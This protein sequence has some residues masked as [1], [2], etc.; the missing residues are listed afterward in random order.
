MSA[1]GQSTEE[2]EKDWKGGRGRR[3]PHSP[4][5]PVRSAEIRW[6]L[7]VKFTWGVPRPLRH[8]TDSRERREGFLFTRSSVISGEAHGATPAKT[9]NAKSGFNKRGTQPYKHLHRE[10]S[11][12]HSLPSVSLP[13][14]PPLFNNEKTSVSPEIIR[15]R[16]FCGISVSVYLGHSCAFGFSSFACFGFILLLLVCKMLSSRAIQRK[17]LCSTSA[18]L[19]NVHGCSSKTEL[20]EI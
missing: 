11:V 2:E 19:Q 4:S 16:G 15:L 18:A 9:P 12:C 8:M 7:D 17:T 6:K 10:I 13:P 14:P 3:T 1:E 20:L 5:I